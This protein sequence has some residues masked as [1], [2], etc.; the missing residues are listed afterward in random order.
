MSKRIKVY[1]NMDLASK[2][3][4]LNVNDLKSLLMDYLKFIFKFI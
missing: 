1:F 4:V 3:N 2:L